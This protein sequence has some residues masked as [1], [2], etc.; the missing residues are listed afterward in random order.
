MPL[1]LPIPAPPSAVKKRRPVPPPAHRR[2][3][4]PGKPAA[5]A[6]AAVSAA[7]QLPR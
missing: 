6:P 2:H 7:G 1:K 4:K 3:R 5:P